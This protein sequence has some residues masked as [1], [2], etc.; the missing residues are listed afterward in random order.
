MSLHDALRIL[1]ASFA[2]TYGFALLLHA[3]RR[4]WIPASLIGGVS[5]TLYWGLTA[6][7]MSDPVAVFISAALGSVLA[8]AC[9]R[10]MRMIAT[11]FLTLSIVTMVPGLGLYRCME[12]L[13][14]GNSGAGAR[15]GV[16][17]MVTILMIALG[18]GVGS[19]VF[20][21]L[22]AKRAQRSAPENIDRKE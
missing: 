16:A 4:A 21:L 8:Q 15:V 7:G 2:A 20:R 12:L 11:V 14:Q 18:L 5:F 1:L 10:R 6:A 3:P 22:F 17:A 9:A 19:F 13:A